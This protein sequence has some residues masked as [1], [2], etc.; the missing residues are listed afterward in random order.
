ML[1]ARL[2]S[3]TK[4]KCICYVACLLDQCKGLAITWLWMLWS[5]AFLWAKFHFSVK[6]SFS[7]PLHTPCAKAKT[8]TVDE[9]RRSDRK[10]GRFSR[11]SHCTHSSFTNFFRPSSLL[12]SKAM[13]RRT[14]KINVLQRSWN[15]R[16]KHAWQQIVV[17]KELKEAD[18][19]WASSDLF[20][21]TAQPALNW[22]YLKHKFD[23]VKYPAAWTE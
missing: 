12:Y 21:R 9:A 16:E 18:F 20:K 19:I 1:T 3:R 13:L 7:R 17:A 10:I 4:Y 2:V 14:F 11:H 6:L 5:L 22:I 8:R 23:T 15:D